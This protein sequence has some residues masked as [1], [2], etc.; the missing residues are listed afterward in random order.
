MELATRRG[1][2]ALMAVAAAIFAAVAGAAPER[3]ATLAFLQQRVADDPIDTGALN[4]LAFAY[5]EKMRATGDLQY[6]E[7]A[8]RTARASL[9]AAPEDRNPGGLAVR[10]LVEFEQHHLK[11]AASFAHPA[12]AI[13]PSNRSAFGTIG[14]AQ[15]ELGNYAEA[16]RIFAG[17]ASAGVS[18]ALTQRASRLAEL[19]GD[20]QHA[21]ELLTQNL[22]MPSLP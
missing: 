20:P 12:I 9:A 3:D 6:L 10:A 4:R 13:D 17:L 1:L 22:E 7:R 16:E 5:I 21:I 2:I 11:E 14:D 19:H 18:T 15:L 8:D